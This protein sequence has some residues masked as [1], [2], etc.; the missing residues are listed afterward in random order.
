MPVTPTLKSYLIADMVFKQ[1]G[2]KWCVIGIFSKLYAPRYPVIHP[3]LGLLIQ[4]SDAEGEYDVKLEVRDS[5]D[6]TI[7]VL[8]RFKLAVHDRLAVVE[9]G[10]QTRHL[11]I[12]A[13]GK[14]R[15]RLSFNDEF[16]G[17]IPLEA[18]LLEAPPSDGGKGDA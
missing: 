8:P 1:E 6:R 5:N 16:V 7:T 4:V 13:L 15:F 11:L 12:P 3:S 9:F 10:T 14:Y 17:D 2:G 18:L